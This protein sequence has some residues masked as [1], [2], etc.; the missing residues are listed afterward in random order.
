[1]TTSN[2]W[3]DALE[4]KLSAVFAND[5][6]RAAARAL[7]LPVLDGPEGS[8]VAVACLKLCDG[9][10]GRLDGSVKV[11]LTDYRDVLAWA[12][13]PRQMRLGAT[14]TQTA[15]ASARREDLKEYSRWLNDS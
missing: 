11:A 4:R 2:M 7:L 15:Q 6:D 1:M 12:E 13:Y 10:L 8:R 14:A 5:P 3:R 9:E